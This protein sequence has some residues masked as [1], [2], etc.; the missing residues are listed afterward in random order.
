[1]RVYYWGHSLLEDKTI[2]TY[3]NLVL[4]IG[5]LDKETGSKID[6][7]NKEE[8]YI[9]NLVTKKNFKHKWSMVFPKLQR[10]SFAPVTFLWE[11]FKRYFRIKKQNSIQSFF[12]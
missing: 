6:A 3:N 5:H 8:I 11:M 12:A 4:D 9:K 10:Q 2:G 1:M 7:F